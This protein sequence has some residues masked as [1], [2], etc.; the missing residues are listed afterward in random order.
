MIDEVKLGMSREVYT[1]KYS[2]KVNRITAKQVN[3]VSRG[4]AGCNSR[5]AWKESGIHVGGL[6]LNC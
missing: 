1:G 4:R 3:K 6:Y 5:R 2:T